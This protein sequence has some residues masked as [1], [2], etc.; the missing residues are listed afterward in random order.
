MNSKNK[1][2]VFFFLS[3]AA[4]IIL[5]AALLQN[6]RT[7]DYPVSISVAG[8]PLPA[9]NLPTLFDT[10]TRLTNQTLQ[11]QVFLL[12]FWA[13]W[14][15]A[16]RA[17]HETLLMIKNDYHVPI[18]GV[19]YKDEPNNAKLWLQ[20]SGDPFTLTGTD[21]NGKLGG[22]LGIYGTP[23]TFIVDKRGVIRYQYIGTLTHDDWQN[24]LWPLIAQYQAESFI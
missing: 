11:G 14:C 18:Y 19:N 9:L 5:L 1:S 16:C 4:L 10:N 2:P 17:E 7:P 6:T 15:S 22:A 21:P 24:V 8:K 3:L 12:N 20:K 23:E 13:S